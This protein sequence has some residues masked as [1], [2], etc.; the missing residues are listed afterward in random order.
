MSSA[1]ENESPLRTRAV[2]IEDPAREFAEWTFDIQRHHYSVFGVEHKQFFKNKV[3]YLS[4][5]KMEPPVYSFEVGDVFYL[6]SDSRVFLQVAADWDA[7]RLEIHRGGVGLDVPRVAYLAQPTE[8]TTWLRTG[9][10]P[11]SCR[12]IDISES[13]AGMLQWQLVAK[14][15]VVP[16]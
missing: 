12:Q 5:A 2:K 6:R 15:T 10:K 4:W 9:L 16:G 7:V 13:Q 1:F 14:S 11:D 8:L 3:P